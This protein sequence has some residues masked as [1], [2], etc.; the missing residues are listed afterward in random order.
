M[1]RELYLTVLSRFPTPEE[2]KWAEA[3]GQVGPADRAGKRAS[4]KR[5]EDWVDIAWALINSTEF[6]YRH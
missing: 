6:L 5:R 4:V 1:I 3:Y 2:M